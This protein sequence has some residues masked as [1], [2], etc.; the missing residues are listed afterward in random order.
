MKRAF[1]LRLAWDGIRKNKKLYIPY[2]LTCVCMTA[3][4]Y[5]VSF[6]SKE[7][8]VQNISGG[9]EIQGILYL[10]S[11]VIGIFSLLI[12]F[13]TNSFLIRRR[14]KEFGLYNILGM[15]KYNLSRVLIWES[16]IVY[17]I[18]LVCGLGFGILFSKFAEL[19]MI[20]ILMEG[21]NFDLKVNFESIGNT[22]V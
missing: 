7:D 15:N 8:S 18:S 20:N 6:L 11:V 4:F 5:I 10:G 9:S 3:M 19:I 1:Y 21:T 16:I 13:Y 17:A 14:K 22:A 2:I 12:L